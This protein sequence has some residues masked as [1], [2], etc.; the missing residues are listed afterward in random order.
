MRSNVYTCLT[1]LLLAAFAANAEHKDFNSRIKY[2]PTDGNEKLSISMNGTWKFKLNG[3]AGDFYKPGFNDSKWDKI[4]VPGNWECQGFEKPTY[5]PPTPAEGLYRRTFTIPKEWSGHHTFIRFEGVGF[6]FEFW[7][8]GKRAGSFASSFNRSDFDITDFVTPGK[9]QTIAVRVYVDPKGWEFDTNDDWGL[10]GIHHDVLLFAVPQMHVE[11][12]TIRT[13]LERDLAKGTIDCLFDINNFSGKPA[14]AEL[15]LSLKDPTGKPV[16]KVTEPVTAGKQL[17]ANLEVNQPMTWNAETP[18]LYDL[19][20]ALKTDGK[21]VHSFTQKVGI[22]K[23]T[24]ENEVLKLNYTPIKMRGVC[25]HD[26]H[27]DTGRASREK[28]YLEDIKLMKEGNINSIRFS[29]YPSQKMFV[30]LCDK[31][32]LYIMDE[33]PFGRGDDHLTDDSYLPILLKRAEA[34]VNRDKNNPSVLIWSVGNENP[35]TDLVLATV[36]KVL[37][38]DPTRPRL[39]PAQPAVEPC[40]IFSTH[41]PIGAKREMK[42]KRVSLE[43]FATDPEIKAPVLPT[44]LTHNRYDMFDGHGERWETIMKY[45]RLG[46]GFI[47]HFQDQGIW[48]EMDED[49]QKRYEKYK[50]LH[51]YAFKDK[52]TIADSN[53]HSGTEGIVYADRLP[54]ENYFTNR[55]IYSQVIVPTRKL[56]TEPG[57]Q[58]FTLDVINRYE[59]TNLDK[60]RA[61]WKLLIDGKE[62]QSG[63]L[64]LSAP[65]MGK[66][67]IDISLKLPADMALHDNVLL[68]EFTDWHGYRVYDRAIQLVTKA[69]RPAF[70]K[71]LTD[72][73]K[74]SES[75]DAVLKKVPFITEPFLRVGRD[76]CFS[77]HKNYDKFKM[78]LWTENFMTD[79]KVLEDKT[80][81]ATVTKKIEYSIKRRGKKEVEKAVADIKYTVA[82][83]GWIDVNYTLTPENMTDYLAEFGLSFYL[84]ENIKDFAWVGNGLCA[85]YPGQDEGEERGIYK[86]QKLPRTIPESR[87]FRGNRTGVDLAAITDDKGNGFGILCNGSTLSI[88]PTDDGLIF[89]QHLKTAGKCNKSGGIITRHRVK[90]DE[91]GVAPGHMRIVPLKAGQWPLLFKDLLENL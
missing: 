90:A 74:G 58:R 21:T 22:R 52:N 39:M 75:S 57:N 45:P 84:P 60:M 64:A 88:E 85:S 56:T 71:R 5:R 89:T 12:L 63:K 13:D 47:W 20:V 26:L 18:H 28:H 70:E 9:E 68:L 35:I 73:K 49:M 36:G 59:F 15:E 72:L 82:P 38:L 65:P 87:Y 80:E 78:H 1:I 54:S 51:D 53:W 23:V 11:D 86:V 33:V 83:E 32:G 46:G 3:P 69:G 81:G 50:K 40:N 10:S 17:R 91:I 4:T 16:G 37:E 2:I 25:R 77:A 44:E 6:G 8:D 14:K 7:V 24:I 62:Q 43:E 31:Y 55:K 34:T 19:D 41:Y 30:D 79:Q 29:H 76:A 27:P 42:M 61:S 66:G 48:R 67:K